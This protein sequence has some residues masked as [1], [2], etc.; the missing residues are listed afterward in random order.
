LPSSALLALLERQLQT[1]KR[2]ELI[3]LVVSLEE[4]KTRAKRR[5]FYDLFPDEGPLRRELYA[6]HLEFFQA[7]AS[8]RER[9]FMAANRVGKT[10]AGGYEDT[11][12]LTGD[13]SHWWPG[14]RFA[15]PTAGWVAGKTN[16]T[17][18]DILQKKLLGEVAWDGPNRIVT[19]TG[20]IPGAL[21]GDITWK[22][23]V[24]NLVDTVRVKHTSGEWSLLGFKSYQ[25]GRGSFEGT[26]QDFIHLD[27]EP[28]IDIYGECLIRTATTGGLVYITYTPLEGLSEVTLSFLPKELRPGS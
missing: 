14:K 27:E 10:I 1:K 21:I 16:E 6:K 25:Q 13:Y 8:Y 9:C 4:S 23:G 19:G 5:Q 22:S 24:P 3:E 7:G 17:T 18:R 15:R 11:C 26:E 20:L 2:D 12:H 28:P